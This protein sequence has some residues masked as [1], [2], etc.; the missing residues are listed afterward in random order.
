MPLTDKQK[1][2]LQALHTAATDIQRGVIQQLALDRIS[3][4]RCRDIGYMGQRI[5][6]LVTLV[7]FEKE[8]K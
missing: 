7:E 1:E 2:H 5:G 8:K 3:L 4:D 6:E